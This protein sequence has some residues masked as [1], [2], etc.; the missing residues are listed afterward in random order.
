MIR[1]QNSGKTPAVS[2]ASCQGHQELVSHFSSSVVIHDQ[3]PDRRPIFKNVSPSR[4]S[5]PPSIDKPQPRCSRQWQPLGSKPASTQ[6]SADALAMPRTS[7]V[8]MAE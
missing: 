4:D 3:D 8:A 2:Y 5:P 1:G 6:Q 7:S